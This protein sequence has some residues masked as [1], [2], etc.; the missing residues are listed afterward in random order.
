MNKFLITVTDAAE[1]SNLDIISLDI[2]YGVNDVPCLNLRLL[3][4]YLSEDQFT[5]STKKI[6]IPG[7]IITIKSGDEKTILFKG[8]ITGLSVG[9]E[10]NY[11]LNVIA[12]GDVVKMTE[13]RINQLFDA[14]ASDDMVI[15]KL[16]EYSQIKP[17]TI[18]ASKIKHNQ[19]FCYQQSPWRVMM[20]RIIA[21][22]FAFVPSPEKNDVIN[23]QNYAAKPASITLN[24]S[25]IRNFQL[26]MD[27]RSQVK[28]ITG[29][30]WNIK[31][32]TLDKDVKG[33]VGKY[34]TFKDSDQVLKIPDTALLSNIPKT[35]DEL[36]IAATAQNN[37]RLLDLYQGHLTLVVLDKSEM[38]NIA[39]MHKLKIEGAGGNFSGEYMVTGIR[40]RTLNKQWIME[41]ELGLPLA[42]T[43]Q[44]DYALLPELPHFI[45]QVA[46]FKLDKQEELERIPI[47]LPALSEKVIWARLLSPYAS[48]KE[49]LFLPPNKGD[50]V[51]VSFLEGD[52]RYP[53]I[54]GS[55]HNP[56][57]KPPILFTD[58]NEIKGLYI[59]AEDQPL[60]L[61]FD[62]TNKALEL[63]AGEES[64][65]VVSA[66]AGISLAKADSSISIAD[67]IDL[68]SKDVLAI[69]TDKDMNIKATGKAVITAQAVEIK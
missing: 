54:V 57:N 52:C 13:G 35:P 34:K 12:H 55:C 28:V 29:N 27:T 69:T 16:M 22:G 64:K 3:E 10:K 7:K 65:A 58:K 17:G 50:E 4:S 46:E 14:A 47:N 40:H 33:E 8:I 19:Y 30:A 66:E 38:P 18:A 41:L 61:V 49:G 23:L 20:A 25:E 1:Q 44:S 36:K 68:A 5:L 24:N 15:K 51:I 59:N 32:Q 11:Y 6:F 21:N 56:V 26:D 42:K 39:L 37:Y 45:G 60:N 43:L 31:T 9:Y 48:N 53:I 2:Y 63:I 62:G 67:N